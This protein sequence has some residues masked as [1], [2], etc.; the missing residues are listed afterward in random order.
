MSDRTELIRSELAAALL[1]EG[2]AV[3]TPD[4]E[5]WR[6][7]AQLGFCRYGWNPPTCIDG[8]NLLLVMAFSPEVIAKV[9]EELDDEELEVYLATLLTFMAAF[10]DDP[11]EDPL[12]IRHSIEDYLYENNPEAL[13]LANEVEASS[14]D[15]LRPA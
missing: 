8:D 10:I 15:R 3:V 4:M 12:K 7:M 5:A 1:R 2:V 6:P 13:A 14:L 9:T 11:T